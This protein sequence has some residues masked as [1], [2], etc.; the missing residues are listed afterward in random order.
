MVYKPDPSP[1]KE[2]DKTKPWLKMAKWK[3]T[4]EEELAKIEGLNLVVLRL[5]HVYGDYSSKFVATALSLARVYQ[6]LGKEMKWLW[7]MDLRV[8]TV[9][10]D[11]ATR[12]IWRAAEWCHQGRKGWN[13]NWG[14][15]ALFNVVDHGKTCK[16]LDSCLS[17]LPRLPL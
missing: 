15:P 2:T 11:D 12:A 16:R 5:A 4:A 17:N 10:I 13:S 14:E 9:H 3:L 8:N 7:D 6:H 1:R